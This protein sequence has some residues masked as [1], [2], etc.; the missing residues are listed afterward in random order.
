[1]NR[2]LEKLIEAATQAASGDNTQAWRFEVDEAAGRIV[3]SVDETRDP[4]PMNAG[5]RM[6]RMAVGGALENLLRAAQQSGIRVTTT[7]PPP[8]AAAAL[9]W[10]EPLPKTPI[11]PDASI[12]RRV[13]NRRPFDGRDVPHEVLE[14][15]QRETPALDGVTAHWIV[16]R[17]RLGDWAKLIGRGDALMFSER[18]MRLAFL[19]KIRFDA[20][21]DAE[22]E[23]GLS[24]AS[25]E[26]AAFD[27]VALRSMPR[28]PNWVVRWG[29]VTNFFAAHARKLIKSS[30][31][32]CL[33]AAPD[34]LAG[35]D[36][37]VGRAVQRAWLALTAQG[38]Q[39]Q[40][41]MSLI[42]LDNALQYGSPQLIASLRRERLERLRQEVRAL[43]PAEA[44]GRPAFLLRFGYGPAPS[45]RVG[46]LPLAASVTERSAR[47]D[48]G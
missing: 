29:G 3:I 42:V 26:L 36:V 38:L 27:R 14:T 32:L 39:A 9:Q 47:T 22:V 28:I 5:Q 46:R 18:S 23:E 17:D 13:T 25:L 43:L 12:F 35:T 37:T 1:M 20:P 30:A 7:A 19:A 45:G 44:D 33:V 40:P 31:G 11:Q 24:L 16:G 41:M 4:S 48:Q 21:P 34:D 8:G 2:T 10:Q 15:L 6:S